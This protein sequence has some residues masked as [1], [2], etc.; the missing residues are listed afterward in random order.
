MSFLLFD[1]KYART[2]FSY[3]CVDVIKERAKNIKLLLFFCKLL[4]N[5]LKSFSQTWNNS[6]L[7]IDEI[8]D[9][10]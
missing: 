3:I 4:E 1:G 6:S 2:C 9:D 7:I 10:P 8:D 5:G